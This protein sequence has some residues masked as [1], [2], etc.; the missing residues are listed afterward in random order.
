M[1]DRRID[2]LALLALC[3]CCS[4]ASAAE[5]SLPALNGQEFRYS[6]DHSEVDYR[7]DTAQL[8]GNVRVDQGSNSIEAEQASVKAFRSDNSRWHF[9]G[10]VRVR[11]ADAALQSQSASAVFE[12]EQLV[13]ARVE[14]SPAE[15]ER[16]GGPGDLFARGR[17]RVIEYDVTSDVVTLQGDVW[18][19]YGEDVFETDTVVYHLRDE[20][21]IAGGT[22]AGRVRG[23]IRPRQTETSEAKPE[24]APGDGAAPGEAAEQNENESGA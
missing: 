24:T 6:F 22:A 15:F 8:S 2:L 3:A 4:P 5:G 7:N 14:G 18:F 16:I 19:G 21:V 23:I 17:A 13:R 20:R 12:N 11:T 9:E 1:T 10:G